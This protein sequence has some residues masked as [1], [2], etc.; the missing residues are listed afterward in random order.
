MPGPA[1]QGGRDQIQMLRCPLQ[2]RLETCV[3]WYGGNDSQH[4]GLCP[5]S[6]PRRNLLQQCLQFG[7]LSGPQL[8]V[9]VSQ[10]ER[11]FHPPRNDVRRARKRLNLPNRRHQTGGVLGQ[12]LGL[13]HPLGGGHQG[14]LA[15]VHGR[16]PGV[17]GAAREGEFQAVVPHQGAD[18]PQRLPGGFQH[19]PLLDVYLQKAQVRAAQGC[20]SNVHV[21]QPEV[22]HGLT[23]AHALAV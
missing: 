16:G 15:Q 17:V 4:L 20:V 19:R 5:H 10:I 2:P 9:S 22:A 18:Q 23:H 1:D 3:Q 12:P 8:V 21:V 7:Q 6:A 14:V 11:Q 13:Q